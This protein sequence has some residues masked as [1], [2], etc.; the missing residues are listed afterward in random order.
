MPK[1]SR[2]L[3]QSLS[4]TERRVLESFYSGRLTAGSLS[5]ALAEARR[6]QPRRAPAV[7]PA[8]VP[9]QQPAPALSYAA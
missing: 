3:P 9:A 1:R 6:E 4:A 8:P 5:A 7:A 2:P